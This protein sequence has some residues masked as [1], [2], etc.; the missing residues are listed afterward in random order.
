M[1]THYYPHIPGFSQ[2]L[3]ETDTHLMTVV[4][5]CQLDPTPLNSCLIYKISVWE[6]PGYLPD[7]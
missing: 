1:T 2:S 6:L 5:L 7:G 3:D 4:D